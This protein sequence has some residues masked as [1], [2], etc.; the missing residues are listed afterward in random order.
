M[1]P[2]LLQKV[3][4]HVGPDYGMLLV[5]TDLDVLAKPTAVVIPRRL[6]IADGLHIHK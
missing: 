4:A 2:G 3:G 1:L 6:G 5:K